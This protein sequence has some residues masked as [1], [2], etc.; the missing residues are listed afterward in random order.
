MRIIAGEYRSRR[1]KTLNGMDVRPT[2]DRLREALFNVLAPRLPGAVFVDAYAGCGSVGIEAISRGAESA[3]VVDSNSQSIKLIEE[4]TK[5]CKFEAKIRIMQQEVKAALPRLVSEAPFDLILLDPPY[6]RE[7]IPQV[8]ETIESLQ[9]LCE[10]GIICAESAS[11][12]SITDCGK[13]QLTES[14][15][16]GASTIHLFSWNED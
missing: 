6:N 13:L 4:N 8:L 9:L 16:Y 12:E 5:R 3:I 11:N 2:P 14:R 7:L 15:K 10:D 1:I